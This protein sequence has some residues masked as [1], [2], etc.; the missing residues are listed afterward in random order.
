[1]QGANLVIRDRLMRSALAAVLV[2]SL[3]AAVAAQDEEPSGPEGIDW[4]LTS[5]YDGNL[6][7]GDAAVG[8]LLQALQDRRRWSNTIVLVTSDH[9]EAFLEHGR[10]GHN[11]T[12]FD[13]MLRIPFILRLPARFAAPLRAGLVT[14]A[15]ILPTFISAAGGVVPSQ[16]MGADLLSVSTRTPGRGFFIARTDRT[17]PVMALRT[18][19]WKIVRS[20]HNRMELF[21]LVADPGEKTDVLHQKFA[22]AMG[23]ERL[24]VQQLQ[25]TPTHDPTT[26]TAPVDD[27]D[28]AM[29]RALGYGD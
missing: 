10:L 22:I 6:R 15:D 16:G 18:S 26:R 7:R 11:S 4:T 1:M 13:E 17:V 3:P 19:R 8:V 29:L 27:D 2:V 28:A 25:A 9:G 24:L 12:V 5:L 20:S 23:L 21:D 14:V